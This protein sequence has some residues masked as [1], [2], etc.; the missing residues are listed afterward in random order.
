M[1]ICIYVCMWCI[2]VCTYVCIYLC[3]CM[4]MHVCIYIYVCIHVCVYLLRGDASRRIARGTQD[5][6]ADPI[7]NLPPNTAHTHHTFHQKSVGFTCELDTL[8]RASPVGIWS[9]LGI[10]AAL[11][12]SLS[13]FSASSIENR[14]PLSGTTRGYAPTIRIISMNHGKNGSKRTCQLK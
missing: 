11:N 1:Y 13:S 6:T 8:C 10:E 7:T 5:H 12:A 14:G 2:Y 3:V 9:S 4:C